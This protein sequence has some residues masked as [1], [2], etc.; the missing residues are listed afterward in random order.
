MVMT[1]YIYLHADLL[2]QPTHSFIY[3]KVCGFIQQV[4]FSTGVSTNMFNFSFV[5]PL[6]VPICVLTL[7]NK[8]SF[9]LEQYNNRDVIILCLALHTS[10]W[11]VCENDNL[12]VQ[13]GV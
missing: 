8:Y 2:K 9:V 12:Y 13:C 4:V 1:P 10:C 7:W 3:S 5:L 11:N 6:C